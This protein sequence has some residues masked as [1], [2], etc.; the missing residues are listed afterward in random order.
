MTECDLNG[1][2]PENGNRSSCSLDQRCSNRKVSGAAEAQEVMVRRVMVLHS[3]RQREAKQVNVSKAWFKPN[4]NPATCS[5]R[6]FLVPSGSSKCI[7]HKQDGEVNASV[8]PKHTSAILGTSHVI[9]LCISYK[10]ANDIACSCSQAIFPLPGKL[11][12]ECW[13]VSSVMTQSYVPLLR[14]R[15]KTGEE[16][17][18][19]SLNRMDI[20]VYPINLLAIKGRCTWKLSETGSKR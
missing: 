15:A 8:P 1:W 20:A 19:K 10:V 4:K 5:V 11:E 9:K 13:P 18:R 3:Q 17:K 6:P 7:S 2:M 14:Y 12:R 16:L